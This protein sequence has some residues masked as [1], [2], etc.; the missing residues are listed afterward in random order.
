MFAIGDKEWPGLS[1]LVEECGEV[2]QIVGRLMQTRGEFR[3]WNKLD[4]KTE[5]ENEIADLKAACMFVEDTCGLDF[6]RIVERREEKLAK[7]R[8]W[9][10]GSNNPDD[11]TAA[12]YTN[13]T[14]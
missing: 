2:I 10:S 11:W 5:L 3:Q 12:N 6:E 14:T 7:Y 9:H 4:L 1:K 8:K 13:R